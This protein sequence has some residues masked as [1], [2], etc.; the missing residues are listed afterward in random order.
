MYR[1]KHDNWVLALKCISFKEENFATVFKNTLAEYFVMKIAS[2]LEVGPMIKP[3]FGFDIII[4]RNCLEFT[5]EFCPCIEKDSL[6]SDLKIALSKLHV[7]RLIHYD[8]KP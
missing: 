7:L 1:I 4:Y 6:E 3:P 2:I 8:I 5:M